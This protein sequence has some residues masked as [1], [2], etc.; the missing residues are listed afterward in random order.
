MM[1]DI[2]QRHIGGNLTHRRWKGNCA[3]MSDAPNLPCRV[4]TSQRLQLSAT[5]HKHIVRTGGHKMPYI[6]APLCGSIVRWAVGTPAALAVTFIWRT[7]SCCKVSMQSYPSCMQLLRC[8]IHVTSVACSLVNSWP[9]QQ[10][11]CRRGAVISWHHSSSI[12]RIAAV[13]QATQAGTSRHIRQFRN[14]CIW[15]TAECGHQS[16]AVINRRRRGWALFCAASSASCYTGS[17]LVAWK[18]TALS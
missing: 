16:L 9:R 3:A 11:A 18:W 13:S 10:M 2:G 5:G 14:E 7:T 4:T 17:W 12:V 1:S 6:A 8:V 15:P